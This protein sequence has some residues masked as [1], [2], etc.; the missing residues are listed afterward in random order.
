MAYIIWQLRSLGFEVTTQ[1]ALALSSLSNVDFCMRKLKA[2]GESQNG[3]NKKE[4][5]QGLNLSVLWPSL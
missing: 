3:T 2:P 1:S 5:Q 4:Q